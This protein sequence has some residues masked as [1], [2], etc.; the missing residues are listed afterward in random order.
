MPL[1][2]ALP[3]I[4]DRRFEDL[5][6]EIR[7]RIPRYAPEWRPAWNDLN[8]NDPGITM[9]QVFAWL[10]DTLIY[11]MNKIPALG[12]VK[13]LQLVGIELH[14]AEPAHAAITFPLKP[15]HPLP[16][17][18]VPLGTQV[19][20]NPPAGGAPVIFETDRAIQALRA[21][22]AA[23]QSFDGFGFTVLTPDNTSATDPFEPFGPTPIDDAA[24]LLG[25]DDTD[26]LPQTELTLMVWADETSSGAAQVTCNLP[27]G[28]AFAP[29]RL[30]WEFWDGAHWQS[31]VVL[32]DE[33]RAFT[34][35]GTVLLKLPAAGQIKPDKLGAEPAP[36][37]WI[38]ARL[39]RTQYERPPS[40]RAV[41][42][43]TVPATQAE[44][45][46]DEVVG[47]SDGSR[48]QVFTLARTPVLALSLELQVDEG[49]GFL[50]WQEVDDLAGAGTDDPVYVLDRT[51][52]DIRF[53]DGVNG[54][55]PT[56]NPA[57]ASGNI[58]ARSYRVGGG[59]QGNV[60][61]A[62]IKTLLAAVD[63]VDD[64]A[65]GNLF[66]AFGGSDEERLDDAKKRAP[67]AIRS[68]DRA[69]TA[70]DFEEL[71]TEVPGI[72]RAKALPLFHPDFPD[73]QVPGVVT[74]IVVPDGTGPS[75]T[76]S[77]GTLRTV[78]AALDS[79]RLL[80]TEL[81]VVAPRYQELQVAVEVVAAD[82]A[83]LA[84]VSRAL[85]AALT[86]YFDPLTGGESGT[87]WPFGGTIFY[88]RV[89]QRLS[90]PGV[91]SITTLVLTLDG[92]AQPVCTDVKLA[93]NALLSLAEP[94]IDVHYASDTEA[95]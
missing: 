29:A 91:D 25:F 46:T 79:K 17:V 22:L 3:V 88:S 57:N 43:N 60:D 50:D 70:A 8:D 12:Y 36:H 15:T 65:V 31:L 19:S 1:A 75:P 9:V 89:Y 87:G 7:Q 2:D 80:T 83:D 23:V 78:C 13:F 64:N 26:P 11:R 94:Q 92:D 14:P 66:A 58:V 85:A 55:I 34:R 74:V 73:V 56:A 18:I 33:T 51:S 10:A 69:V 72:R 68:H 41:R 90:V 47:G 24:L 44:T 67:L 86:G 77:E 59:T 38:R 35:T 82:D 4:D 28:A 27:T 40:L 6:T 71:A 21:A 93:A 63:G 95:T 30:R 39:E 5:L 48:D 32:K 52:G 62:L 37:A 53:G 61:A 20:A 81:Y 49:S 42:T 54:R 76:P 84:E 16:S 45:V